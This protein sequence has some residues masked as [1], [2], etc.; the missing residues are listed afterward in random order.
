MELRIDDTPS[1]PGRDHYPSFDHGLMFLTAPEGQLIFDIDCHSHAEGR[2]INVFGAIY[3]EPSARARSPTRP[4]DHVVS[5]IYLGRLNAMRFEIPLRLVEVYF[6]LYPPTSAH[7]KAM[8]LQE[9]GKARN[10]LPWLARDIVG[11]LDAVLLSKDCKEPFSMGRPKKEDECQSPKELPNGQTVTCKRR[12][13][14][15]GPHTCGQYT[16]RSY[17]ENR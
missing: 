6:E 15:S 12:I 14:H 9:A 5:M 13:N 7:E 17:N 10:I 1:E 2:L 8:W 16:W 4:A 11:A 3:W